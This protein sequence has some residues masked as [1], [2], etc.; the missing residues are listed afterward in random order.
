L[1]KSSILICMFLAVMLTLGLPLNAWGANYIVKV[2]AW[3]VN[4]SFVKIHK[5][6]YNYAYKIYYRYFL[7]NNSAESNN[8]VAKYGDYGSQVYKIEKMLS[9]L[10]YDVVVSKFFDYRTQI[11]VKKFQRD[12]NLPQ[13]GVVDKATY[14]KIKQLYEQSYQKK[15]NGYPLNP[16][17]GQNEN[18]NSNN[19]IYNG[20]TAEEQQMINLVNRERASRGIPEL[21]VDMDL[22][23]T[24][25][26]KSRD[27]VENNY[28][29]HQSPTYGSP[30]D[31]MRSQGISY[32]LAGEN[33]AGAPSVES[34]H[35]NLMN[36]PGH[37]AN[38][39]NPN[40]THV[41][42]GI[43][44]GGPYGKMFTQ[45]FIGK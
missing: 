18:P 23:K 27:M 15:N 21:K 41:G 30:F 43:V 29:A 4:N 39:L 16:P 12:V 35:R 17:T 37:R 10:G 5:T 42:I 22:V 1:R 6:S 3:D 2:Y 14:E 33:L 7:D 13:T 45:H 36:S 32:R 40:F 31:L 28:F 20:L 38:I 8:T 9:E 19:N 25:R 11:M 34:A 26:M 24:A 44:D